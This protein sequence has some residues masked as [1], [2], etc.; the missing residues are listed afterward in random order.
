ML[1]NLHLVGENEDDDLYSEFKEVDN[2]VGKDLFFILSTI[3]VCAHPSQ[4]KCLS[5]VY[6]HSSICMGRLK[7]YSDM[8]VEIS[9]LCS[10]LANSLMFYATF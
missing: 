3:E 6:V 10:S 5:E 1:K 2:E 9:S 4:A 7:A 8:H